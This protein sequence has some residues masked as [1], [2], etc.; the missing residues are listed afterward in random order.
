[1]N[2]WRGAKFDHSGNPDA[3]SSDT[4]VDEILARTR[5][6]VRSFLGKFRSVTCVESVAQEKINKRGGLEY[7]EKSTFD[8]LILLGMD[9]HGLSVEESRL[10][11]KGKSK[12]KDI[13]L[14][15]SSGLPTLLLAFH[16]LYRDDFAYRVDGEET[17]G[18][19]RLVKIRFEHIPGTKST[20]ALRLRGKDYPLDLQGIAWIDPAAGTVYK[21]KAGISAP[22]DDLNLKILEME[23]SYEPHQFSPG[24]DIYWLPSKA[25]VSIQTERQHWRN[26]HR[27]SGY[28][29]FM[30]SSENKVMK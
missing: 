8:Y 4:A 10:K 12:R 9:A 7:A 29:R 25:T 21:I 13:P 30:V 19:N 2:S 3:P 6:L 1:M 23:V 18:A 11:Q 14:L 5:N 28:K 22:A 24:E 27:Y 15:T 20:T 17:L 16:P 26:V